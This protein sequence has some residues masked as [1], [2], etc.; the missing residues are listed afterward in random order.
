MLRCPE[1]AEGVYEVTFKYLHGL[2]GDDADK[3]R[4]WVDYNAEIGEHGDFY[5]TYPVD[6]PTP[7]RRG[8]V[9]RDPEPEGPPVVLEAGPRATEAQPYVGE[10]CIHELDWVRQIPGR[11]YNRN[12]RYTVRRVDG[13]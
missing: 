7:S 12:R 8:A 11:V 1:P 3:P 2:Y 5:K 4:G 10:L 9:V 13:E 6:H